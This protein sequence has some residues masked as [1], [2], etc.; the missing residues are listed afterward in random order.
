V[1]FTGAIFTNISH[2]HLDYHKTMSNYINAKKKFFDLLPQDAFAIVNNDDKNGSVM[3][4]N[5]KARIRTYGLRS[6][7]DYK[8]KILE[9]SIQGL[10]LKI[11][12][13][14][15][16]F[17]L[18]GAFNAYNLLC[19]YGAAVELGFE[20]ELVLSTLSGLKGADGRFEQIVDPITG[21]CGIVDYA[22]TPDALEN[23]LE[24]IKNIKSKSSQIITVVG[25]GGDRDKTKR[26]VMSKVAC[27][28]SDKVI[29]TS[30]NPRTENPETILDDMEVGLDDLDKQKM[31]RIAD[32]NQAIKT[33]VMIS[34]K[35]DIILVAGKGHENYQEINGEKFPFDDKKIL[36]SL[37]S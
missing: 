3:V 29:L 24:T 35:G 1:S 33:A 22:H 23:V 13:H 30:D 20:S 15:A 2:D 10:H 12:G 9:S 31:I 14:E 27:K 8:A 32:R 6:M 17:R 21:T 28:F 37:F 34:N 19:V 4:Q 5:T 36:K 16:F 25:C 18:I 26:P 11:N 7:T